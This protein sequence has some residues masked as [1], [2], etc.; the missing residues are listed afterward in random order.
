MTLL[1]QT[2][3]QYAQLEP[4]TLAGLVISGSFLALALTSASRTLKGGR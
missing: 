3:T 4:M 2:I 1:I